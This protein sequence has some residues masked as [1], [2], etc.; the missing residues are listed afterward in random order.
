M[1]PKLAEYAAKYASKTRR[2]SQKKWLIW[3]KNNHFIVY[4]KLYF[5]AAK[6]AEKIE[7]FLWKFFGLRTQMVYFSSELASKI[8][9]KIKKICAI[10]WTFPL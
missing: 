8:N 3:T 2:K 7:N 5:C 4:Q 9:F 10:N 6:K 1:P